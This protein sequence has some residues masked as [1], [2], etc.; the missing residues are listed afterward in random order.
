M[1]EILRMSKLFVQQ[2][3]RW[4]SYDNFPKTAEL[5]VCQVNSHKIHENLTFTGISTYLD[6]SLKSL[7]SVCTIKNLFKITP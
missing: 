1:A 4:R 6:K 2:R 5:I 3:R 7:A